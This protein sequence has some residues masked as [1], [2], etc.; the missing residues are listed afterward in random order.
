MTTRSTWEL[1]WEWT[2]ALRT[3][4]A[5]NLGRHDGMSD[6]LH[7]VRGTHG[8]RIARD[9]LV[10]SPKAFPANAKQ[11]GRPGRAGLLE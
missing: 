10:A 1:T 6:R 8:R 5:T 11:M 4:E 7:H 3:N 9:G 2:W